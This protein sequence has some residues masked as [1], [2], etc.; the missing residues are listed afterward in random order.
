ML[1]ACL[2]T[3]ERQ[4][5]LTSTA[6]GI[7]A[8]IYD[9]TFA[10]LVIPAAYFG[11]RAHKPRWIG[12]GSLMVGLGSFVFALPQVQFIY[13]K[14]ANKQT[15]KYAIVVECACL[16]QIFS[17]RKAIEWL[18][19]NIRLAVPHSFVTLTLMS[20][21]VRSISLAKG[22]RFWVAQTSLQYHFLPQSLC[23]CCHCCFHVHRWW[24]ISFFIFIFVQFVSKEYQGNGQQRLEYC[25]LSVNHSVYESR[26][27]GIDNPTTYGLFVVGQ[28]MIAIGAMPAYTMGLSFLDEIASP[29][30]VHFYLGSFFIG[31][32]IGPALGFLLSSVF[33]SQYV[34]PNESNPP[35][36]LDPSF[37]GRWWAGYIMCGALAI[38]AS[39]PLLAF[40]RTL[41]GTAWIMEEKRDKQRGTG[42]CAKAAEHASN[43]KA[44]KATTDGPQ[45]FS[46]HMQRFVQEFKVM[47]RLAMSMMLS[48]V[49]IFNSLGAAAESF[50][51]SHTLQEIH[52]QHIAH[53]YQPIEHVAPD[54]SLWSCHSNLHVKLVVVSAWPNCTHLA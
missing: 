3:I 36:P 15:N 29:K 43:V 46:A 45:S 20:C 6:G 16:L 17:G 2:S 23:Q 12:L 34:N 53:A 42:K 8:G 24:S 38:A 10:V 51:V 27:C 1:S 52:H 32:A 7:L 13:N 31:A 14:Q 19:F 25:G 4:Y 50:A 30:T 21:P 22:P 5:S 11:E 44:A 9:V 18:Y 47:A 35:D 39:V 49:V 40:P 41:P 54:K 48:G 37:V 28:I 33:L 26:N